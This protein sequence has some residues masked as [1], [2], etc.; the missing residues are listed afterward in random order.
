LSKFGKYSVEYLPDFHLKMSISSTPKT[1]S[2][3]H[4]ANIYI[5]NNTDGI[6]DIAMSHQYS[7]TAV[8]SG[9]WLNVAPG[10]SAGP[11][12][13]T[14]ETGFGTGLDYWFAEIRIHNGSTSGIYTSKGSLTAPTKECELEG[15][16]ANQNIYNAVNSTTFNINL[17][18]GGCSTGMSYVGPYTP[19]PPPPVSPLIKNVFVLMLENH[20]FDNLFGFSNLQGTDARYSVPTSVNGVSN[21]TNSYNNFTYQVQQGCGDPMVSDPGHEFLQTME[22]LCGAGTTNPFASN[23]N[24]VYP[25][26]DNSG[27]VASYATVSGT[28]YLPPPP[29][30]NYGDIMGCSTSVNQIPSLY[31]LAQNF[32]ICDNW[33]SSLPGPTWPNRLFA[34][35]GSS[36]GLDDSPASSQ[37][38]K[39]ETVSG[40]TYQNGSIFDLLSA[41]SLN[42]RIYNDDTDLFVTNKPG[43]TEGGQFAIASALK[44]ITFFTVNSLANFA[45]DLQGNYPYQYTWIEPNYGNAASDTYSNGSSQHPMDSLA[46][47]DDLVAFVYN[48]IR[49]SPLWDQ[50]VLII[51]YDEHGGFYD[52]V[53]PTA[54]PAPGDAQTPGLNTNGFNFTNYGVRV[55]A[56]IV[57]P[58]VRENNIDHTQYDHTSILR[59][60]E[61][62]F[63]TNPTHLT[64]R[65]L[66]AKDFMVPWA[67]TTLRTNCINNLP[68]S[69]PPTASKAAL[70]QITPEVQAAIDLQ[71]LPESGNLIGFLHIALKTEVELSDGSDESKKAIIEKFEREVKTRGD[72]KEYMTSVYNRAKAVKEAVEL[73]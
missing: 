37:I 47:G 46:A 17:T 25:T 20:S 32:V 24:A 66:A 2:T 16:D 26:I 3:S 49:N 68:Y 14:F 73:T 15:G 18:S 54:A 71:P 45:A 61:N 63:K 28:G 59:M 10:A 13:V 70:P 27:F 34:M 31:A 48:T 39:W 30:Q 19:P 21:Q 52:H 12:V 36:A 56:V 6:A 43:I 65:D 53:A 62:L 64:Q 5:T 67:T 60:V 44:G 69:I 51:T 72:A 33:F 40:F 8:Q 38:T 9:Q 11:L 1:M 22:Q 58:L 29:P 57:S 41:N 7:S 55:P 50:S 4:N 35:G 42:W 23:P